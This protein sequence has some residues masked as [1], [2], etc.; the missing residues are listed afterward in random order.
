MEAFVYSLIKGLAHAH[1]MVADVI[2]RSAMPGAK[3]NAK[4]YSKKN[5][6]E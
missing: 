6:K 1:S 2:A 3:S 5:Q 4:R